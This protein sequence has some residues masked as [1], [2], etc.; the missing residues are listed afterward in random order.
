MG[1]GLLARVDGELGVLRG[2]L[3]GVDGDMGEYD[4]PGELNTEETEEER[5]LLLLGP[6][7][8]PPDGRVAS[9]NDSRLDRSIARWM[10]AANALSTSSVVV[11]VPLSASQLMGG[12]A[13]LFPLPS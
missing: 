3:A 11:L 2:L 9:L 8:P 7:S 5:L 12:I 13:L 6:G 1:L 4:A 10:S